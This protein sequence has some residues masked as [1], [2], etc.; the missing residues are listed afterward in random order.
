MYRLKS[1]GDRTLPCGT[2]CLNCHLAT[3]FLL[4][5]PGM[6]VYQMSLSKVSCKT[7]SKAFDKS[8]ATTIVREQGDF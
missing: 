3:E 4:M 5:L 8:R 1:V 2:P 7:V 6:S